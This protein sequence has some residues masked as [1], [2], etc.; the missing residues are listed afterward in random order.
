MHG[1]ATIVPLQRMEGGKAYDPECGQIVRDESEVSK[2]GME[3]TAVIG[4]V[5][6]N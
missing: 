1:G 6:Q 2:F 3:M 4:V 5:H